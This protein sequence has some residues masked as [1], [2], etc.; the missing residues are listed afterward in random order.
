MHPAIRLLFEEQVEFRD[1]DGEP[2][3]GS[4]FIC[5]TEIFALETLKDDEDAFRNELS[6]WFKEDWLPKQREKYE[7]L[8]KLQ[9]NARRF[10][11]LC[12]AICRQQVVPFI[13]SGMSYSS[14][15]PV[16]SDLLR[17]IRRQTTV[18]SAQL[19]GLLR[20]WQYEEAAELLLSATNQ[21]L[22]NESIEHEL[23]VSDGM[24]I[25][26]AVRL[27]PA[28]FPSLVVTTN[29]DNLLEQ[30]YVDCESGFDH[31]MS[32]REV[33]DYRSA[34]SP[35]KRFL[36]KLH[37][38]RKNLES[39]IIL[40]SEY[41]ASYNAGSTVREELMLLYR[42]YHLL[43]MGCSLGADRTMQL[44]EEVAKDDK[45]MPKHYALLQL[46]RKE[47]E[48]LDRERFLS[49]RNIYP[50]WYAGPHDEAIMALL[51]GL[52]EPAGVI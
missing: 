47:K 15:L 4:V 52:L 36:L 50:I 35:R 37:G 31:V 12:N 39:R 34:K 44:I 40:R 30:L 10:D 51:A 20:S 3:D 28:L 16:W 42:S 41:D 7:S 48:R 6:E 46:P 21:N 1:K 13:G 9:S 26:G 25:A 18:R 38:D 33:A 8:L 14:G 11:E 24:P 27:L 43:F 45:H 23:S 29:L 19:E 5:G 17:N 22:F 49:E 32:G 2:I